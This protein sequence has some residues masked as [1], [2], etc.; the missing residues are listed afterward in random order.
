MGRRH[1]GGVAGDL[2][3]WQF[4]PHHSPL[5]RSNGWCIHNYARTL[6]LAI[7]AQMIYG[8]QVERSGGGRIPHRIAGEKRVTARLPLQFS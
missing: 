8:G 2:I 1:Y 6:P 5:N 4:S 7:A 3:F